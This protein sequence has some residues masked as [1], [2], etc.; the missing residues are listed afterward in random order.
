MTGSVRIR[1]AVAA[2]A[3]RL[4]GIARAA[5]AGWGYAP[6]LLASWEESLRITGEYV[7]RERVYVLVRDDALVGFHALE[8]RE[9][10]WRLEHLW[11]DPVAQGSGFGRRLFE[12]AMGCVRET[13]PGRVVIEADPHAAGFYARMEARETGSVAA[14]VEG[15][16]GRRLPVFE[17]AVT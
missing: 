9:D 16:P 11:V 17:I 8:Q 14:P 3:P 1:R 10:H 6:A 2:E 4:S 5:K 15:D 12:H 7:A 13:R